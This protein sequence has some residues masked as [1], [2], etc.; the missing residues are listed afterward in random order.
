[1]KMKMCITILLLTTLFLSNTKAQIPNQTLKYFTVLTE[2]SLINNN[3]NSFNGQVGVNGSL[4]GIF[5]QS[6]SVFG[7]T[8]TELSDAL[9]EFAD[10][11][12]FLNTEDGTE[13]NQLNEEITAGI[14]TIPSNYETEEN[15]T[16]KFIG[17]NTDI[18][19]INVNGNLILEE[20]TN[21]ILQGI[22]P[23]N[24]YWN[25]AGD[26]KIRQRSWA[27]GTFVSTGNIIIYEDINGAISTFSESDITIYGTNA[28]SSIHY[29]TIGN[30][31]TYQI[32]CNLPCVESNLIGNGD[33]INSPNCSNLANSNSFYTDL[34]YIIPSTLCFNPEANPGLYKIDNGLRAWNGYCDNNTTDHTGNGSNLF[35]VDAFSTE[36]FNYN[37]QKYYIDTTNTIIWQKEITNIEKGKEYL[38]YFWSRNINKS[39]KKDLN[40]RITFNGVEVP[41][42]RAIIFSTDLIWRQ[43]CIVWTAPGIIGEPNMNVNISIKQVDVFNSGRG[44]DVVFD[45]FTF[46]KRGAVSVQIT[47][48]STSNYCTGN[49]TTLSVVNPIVGYT[50]QWI[51]NGTIISG[52]IGSTYIAT[53]PGNY[54]VTGN[55]N[56][57]CLLTSNVLSVTITPLNGE[58]ISFT[59]NT[60]PNTQVWQAGAGN[61]PFGS[62]NGTVW[63]KSLLDIPNGVNLTIKGMRFEFGPN[64]IVKIQDGATLTLENEGGTPTIFTSYNCANTMW[65]GVEIYSTTTANGVLNIKSMCVIEH[66]RIGVSN[67]STNYKIKVNYTGYVEATGAIFRNNYIAVQLISKAANGSAV[68]RTNKSIFLS[69]QF[70]TTANMKDAIAYSDGRH[71]TFIDL[72]YVNG[73]FLNGTIFK[74]SF[75]MTHPVS[76]NNVFDEAKVTQNKGISSITSSY[77][78][79]QCEF[80]NL[81]VGAD[82]SSGSG[83]YVNQKF[84]TSYFKSVAY[85][86]ILRGGSGILVGGCTFMVDPNYSTGSTKVPKFFVGINARGSVGYTFSNN[87]FSDGYCGIISKSAGI[88]N[89]TSNIYK[90]TFVDVGKKNKGAGQGIYMLGYNL[91]VQVTCNTFISTDVA[92]PV[93]NHWVSDGGMSAQ[94]HCD[95]SDGT[96][97]AG[98]RFEQVNPVNADIWA[99][100]DESGFTYNTHSTSIAEITPLFKEG[101]A[102]MTSV[103]VTNC[104][105]SY[106]TEEACAGAEP[107]DI[108]VIR[109]DINTAVNNEDAEALSYLLFEAIQYYEEADT[110]GQSSIELLNETPHT[111]AKWMLVARYIQAERYDDANDL[112]EILPVNTEEE[113]AEQTFY[114]LLVQLENNDASMIELDQS[115]IDQLT[116]LAESEFYVS[117]EAQG[118]LH[119][120]YGNAYYIP[121]PYEEE[122]ESPILNPDSTSSLISK[123]SIYPNPSTGTITIDKPTD[124]TIAKIELQNMNGAVIVSESVLKS[125]QVELGDVPNGMYIVAIYTMDG[126]RIMK[127]LIIAK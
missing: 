50:Y 6:D 63:I 111:V 43:H 106:D 123:L 39:Q 19:I 121:L 103:Y 32:P 35:F 94:G 9:A 2:S 77:R 42:T 11:K 97:P 23:E 73:V 82:F 10:F 66:A 67:E 120:L 89:F 20:S 80:I 62:V 49:N 91:P 4:Y 115:A 55:S 69:C 112:L 76:V 31:N 74:N 25:I 105:Q 86:I 87:I 100:N 44:Q 116:E 119:Y 98:N 88:K 36:R 41:N 14:Y 22:L 15:Q 90:N 114:Q 3:P 125:N 75:H 7:S 17:S 71:K 83:V 58:I 57:G 118:I 81:W 124:V 18:I 24:I 28:F 47:S 34:L 53:N 72:S 5:A 51:L 65:K 68:P 59:V 12:I 78:I 27:Y 46:G 33:F 21:I 61:N 85:G 92:S 108:N 84:Q 79:S 40:L 30:N 52:A 29:L 26:L 54:S 99:K 93:K 127:K 64:A 13:I 56:Q 96:A 60:S 95:P 48:T 70:L 110:T 109:D 117:Y 1:M 102:N 113:Q 104:D 16:I 107:R 45:D 101:T 38:F 8:T 37:T 126:D 122:S